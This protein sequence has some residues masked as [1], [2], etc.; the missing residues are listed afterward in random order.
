MG[1]KS[2]VNIGDKKRVWYF[3]R[4]N[5]KG[6]SHFKFL[7]LDGRIILKWLLNFDVYVLTVLNPI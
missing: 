3:G 7:K 2:I 4:N 6:T 5:L 1:K